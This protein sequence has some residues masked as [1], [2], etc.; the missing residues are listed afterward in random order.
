MKNIAIYT[1]NE[2]RGYVHYE[3]DTKE[4][5]VSFSN[6]QIRRKIYKYLTTE[7]EFIL[8]A[9]SE[10]GDYMKHITVPTENLGFFELSLCEMYHSIGVHVDWS[11]RG[12]KLAKSGNTKYIIVN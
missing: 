10:I 9:S 3:E 8:P 12:E 4:V 11:D 7:R 6:E 2:E 1:D 5:L